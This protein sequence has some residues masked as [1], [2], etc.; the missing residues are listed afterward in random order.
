MLYTITIYKKNEICFLSK[1]KAEF[2][3]DTLDGLNYKGLIGG[4]SSG[5]KTYGGTCVDLRNTFD[6][7]INNKDL[8][9]FINSNAENFVFEFNCDE[10]VPYK[11]EIL[12]T[13]NN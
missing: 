2:L 13:F 7:D 11:L 5:I 6:L 12:K 4:Y 8:L 3:F 1:I 10:G 9:L